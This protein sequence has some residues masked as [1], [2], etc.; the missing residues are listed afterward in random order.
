MTHSRND[1]AVGVA[2]PLASRIAGQD[3]AGLGDENDQFGGLGRNGA[4]HTPERV[5]GTLQPVGSSYTFE[6]GKIYNLNADAIIVGPFGHLPQ[7]SGVCPAGGRGGLDADASIARE[8]PLDPDILGEGSALSIAVD[9]PASPELLAAIATNRPFPAGTIELGR[10]TVGAST[11]SGL[12]FKSGATAVSFKSS[13][14]V[15]AGIG[16]F[17]SPADAARQPSAPGIER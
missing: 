1:R 13:A 6:P 8:F 15:Q 3:A 14:D 10:I 17:E 2:Y 5:V 7:R 12:A 16:V 9:A 4:Q 11:G